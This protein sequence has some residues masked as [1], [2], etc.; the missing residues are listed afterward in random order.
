MLEGYLTEVV[1]LS[2]RTSSLSLNGFLEEEYRRGAQSVEYNAEDVLTDFQQRALE[3]LLDNFPE[4]FQETLRLPPERNQV[5]PINL[6]P[7]QGPISVRPYRYPHHQ[8]EEIE[9]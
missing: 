1:N 2:G 3:H 7:E 8:K 5:H 4:V 9:I 6:Q